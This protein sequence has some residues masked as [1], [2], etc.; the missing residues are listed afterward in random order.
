M[1]FGVSILIYVKVDGFVFVFNVPKFIDG[2]RL[3]QHTTLQIKIHFLNLK[4]IY[5]NQSNYKK[6]TNDLM[7]I[8]DRY[9]RYI[10][11]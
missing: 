11:E 6:H 8:I 9:R 4:K 3:L 10:N 7:I 1:C 2:V 5:E